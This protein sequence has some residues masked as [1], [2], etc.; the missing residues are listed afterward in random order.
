MNN[1]GKFK[2]YNPDQLYLLPPDLKEWLAGDGL[3]YFI[4]DEVGTL[5]F[6]GIFTSYDSWAEHLP[7]NYI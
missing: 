5:D 1:R 3:D 2:V 4:M 7:T 6:A